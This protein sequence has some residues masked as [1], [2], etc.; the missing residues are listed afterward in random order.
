L[1]GKR[2]RVFDLKQWFSSFI[3]CWAVSI[4]ATVDSAPHS[5]EG[6][7]I[8]PGE[9][10]GAI[11]VESRE[12]LEDRLALRVLEFIAQ[13]PNA[14]IALPIG[15]LARGLAARLRYYAEFWDETSKH[16]TQRGLQVPAFPNTNQIRFVQL[17]EYFPIDPNSDAS[18]TRLI[19]DLYLQP[20]KILPENSLTMKE[21]IGP[22]LKKGGI[23][24]VFPGG[25]VDLNLLA[26]K[27]R[28]KL[29]KKQKAALE[30]AKLFCEAY[31]KKIQSWG[32]IDLLIT[33]MGTDGHVAYNFPGSQHDSATRLT[34]LSY[35][36]AA[37][38]ARLFGGIERV[39]YRLA[40]TIGLGT[41]RYK[42]DAVVIV[43]SFGDSAA[44]A[45][46]ASIE[47]APC[48]QFPAT[49]LHVL[50]NAC[51][52]V[53]RQ[54]ASEL[55]ERSAALYKETPLAEIPTVFLDRVFIETSLK[56]Q[57]PILNLTRRD[58]LSS[59]GGA[60]VLRRFAKDWTRVKKEA[61]QRLLARLRPIDFSASGMLH[62]AETLDD[63]VFACYPILKKTA[64]EGTFF[65]LQH[66]ETREKIAALLGAPLTSMLSG[67]SASDAILKTLQDHPPSAL[68]IPEELE[69]ESFAMSSLLNALQGSSLSPALKIW[70]YRTPR[71]RFPLYCADA[72][73]LISEKDMSEMYHSCRDWS[74]S[75]PLEERESSV[76]AATIEQWI[77]N[78]RQL[79]VLLGE[80]SFRLH[81]D[82][83]VR[84]ARGIL[85]LRECLQSNTNS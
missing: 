54:S 21:L 27:A 12:Q 32:G 17:G 75:F 33:D 60:L 70:S 30:E 10:I 11:V 23:E 43:A 41:M 13:K 7:A 20:L 8:C 74:S 9:K 2:G 35:T 39:R 50:P 28:S 52:Y 59:P 71:H 36:A 53:T 15:K 80:E 14:V 40:A 65:A 22:T 37:T 25:N 38:A 34:P 1:I 3:L 84:D 67:Q 61:H 79:E 76:A 62:I 49:A 47:G 66:N 16:R 56:K 26:R 5:E 19:E 6:T 45:V 85:L 69:E 55:S 68:L 4:A 82:A 48:I 51:F 83:A 63:M 57:K 29:E 31:E 24:S 77:E 42:P 44:P 73:V 72:Y 78:R 64:K 18:C 58:L 81:P 46:A